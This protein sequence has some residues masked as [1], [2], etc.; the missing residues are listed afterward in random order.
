MNNINCIKTCLIFSFCLLCGGISLISCEEDISIDKIDETPY[1][2]DGVYCYLQNI[3]GLQSRVI[4]LYADK[5]STAQLRVGLTSPADYA[6]DATLKIDAA[7]LETYNEEHQTDFELLPAD[8]VVAGMD[9]TVTVVPGEKE[10]APLDIVIKPDRRL[11]KG[12]TYALPLAIASVTDGIKLSVSGNN[13]YLF[14]VRMNGDT[15]STVKASGI[16]NICYVE[17]NENNP[18]NVGEYTMKSTGQPFFD[19]VF[20]FSSNINYQDETGKVYVYNNSNVQY[21]LDNREKYIKPLQDKGIKV[22]MSILGNHDIVGPANLTPESARLFAGELKSYMDAYGLD[23]V[24]FDDEYVYYAYRP[25]LTE[26]PSAEAYGRLC[27]E[28]KKVM[29]DKLLTMYDIGWST[30]MGNVA[31]EG[32]DIGDIIDYAYHAFYNAWAPDGYKHFKGMRK[33]QWGPYSFYVGESGGSKIEEMRAEGYGVNY[34]YDMRAKNYQSGFNQ[35]GLKLYDDEVVFSGN[36]F[37]KDW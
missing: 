25:G 18:L 32:I 11:T 26:W 17:V 9:E 6:V 13:G 24:G 5:N 4:E 8:L 30:E 31:I 27:Y 37:N 19:V 36:I 16:I 12:Q 7:L 3:A 21:L 23:G 22:C 29:P 28:V 33:K 1:G 14:L 20:L 15:P 34:M 2:A 35:V 10:A